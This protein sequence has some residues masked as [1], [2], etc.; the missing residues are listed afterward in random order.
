MELKNIIHH[1]LGC[2][3]QRGGLHPEIYLITGVRKTTSHADGYTVF[4]LDADNQEDAFPLDEHIKLILRPLSSMTEEEKTEI[5]KQWTWFQDMQIFSEK[6]FDIR[7]ETTKNMVYDALI[8]A[9][10]SDG[11]RVGPTAYFQIVPYMCKQGFD[12]FNLIPTN[13]AIDS[14]KL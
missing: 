3:I 8:T 5:A 12:L 6:H 7:H 11:D 2:S 10:E 13:Q 1:Y 4:V 9:D 14:T